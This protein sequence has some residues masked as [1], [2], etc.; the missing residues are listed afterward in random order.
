MLPAC[1]RDSGP[2]GLAKADGKYALQVLDRAPEQGFASGAFH[3]RELHAAIDRRDPHAGALLRAAVIAYA[4]AEH[5]LAIPA[6]S[7][8]AAWGQRAAPYDAA[9]EL[10]A[11]LRAGQFRAW[12]DAQPPASPLYRTLQQAYVATLR[13]PQTP[14]TAAA[15]T[16][17]RANLERLRWLPRTEP[18]TRIDVNIASASLI[19]LVDGQPQL[20]MRT[21]SGKPGDETP[22]LTSTI[23]HLVLN[24]PWHVPDEIADQEL[25]PKGEGYLSSHGFVTDDSGRLVQQ[26]GPDSALGLVKFEFDNP[27]AVYLH[28]TPAKSAFDRGQRAVSHGCVRLE[29]ALD[30]ADRL[31][32]T[33]AGWSP[34]R[35][36]QVI[37]S[38]ETTTVKLE[39]PVPV[40]LLYLTAVPS[41]GRIVTLPDVYG[42]DPQVVSLLDR[43]SG[44]GAAT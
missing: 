36:R 38:G 4:R 18:P 19:Y 9:R 31:L 5:G 11:A 24:P 29:R 40:R 2:G 27:Y 10:D 16:T 12:L 32:G 41:E 21:A 43:F 25:R 34:E 20:T 7:R 6:A 17:L 3:V 8:P 44:P 14:Q 28:D 22:I 42:W 39:R 35:I 13:Q 30:L 15:L 26:P 37:D 23:D 33:Q 1:S